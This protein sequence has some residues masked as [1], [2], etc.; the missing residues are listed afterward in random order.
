MKNL[1]VVAVTAA[2]AVTSALVSMPAFAADAAQSAAVPDI[3]VSI[4]TATCEN[5]ENTITVTGLDAR[6]SSTAS[7]SI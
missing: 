1:R 4:A 6:I 7:Y 5:P 2:F 3:N